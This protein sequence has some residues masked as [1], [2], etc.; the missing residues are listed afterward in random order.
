VSKYITDL[1]IQVDYKIQKIIHYFSRLIYSDAVILIPPTQYAVGTCAE[2]IRHG[3]ELA[4]KTNQNLVLIK[5]WSF[6]QILGFKHGN[7]KLFD[8]KIK[9]FKND[10]LVKL[11][12]LLIKIINNIYFAFRRML[13]MSI[14]KRLGIFSAQQKNKMSFPYYSYEYVVAKLVKLKGTRIAS[15]TLDVAGSNYKRSENFLKTLNKNFSYKNK[16]ICIHVRSSVYYNDGN[17]RNFRNADASNYCALINKAIADGYMVIVLGKVDTEDK[18]SNI[19]SVIDLRKIKH[20]D[21]VDICAIKHCNIYVGMQSGPLD[22]ALLLKKN[23]LI[24]NGYNYTHLSEYRSKMILYLKNVQNERATEY[25][26]NLPIKI[27]NINT[28]NYKRQWIEMSESEL[29]RA[30]IF[31]KNCFEN[32]DIF[33]VELQKSIAMAA[34][35]DI[36]KSN[37]LEAMKQS[38]DS[39]YKL[40]NGYSYRAI[41]CNYE[42]NQAMNQNTCIYK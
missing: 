10:S 12:I 1:V 13:F 38:K 6:N 23:I 27:H 2:E 33:E 34:K 19:E 17:R 18:I 29:E 21:M 35:V 4:Q 16:Y 39:A 20:D 36:V 3:Y 37:L 32:D 8:L 22:L 40:S 31:A 26:L 25:L 9:E 7:S 15:F 42:A 24:V 41:I 30:F 14:I 5:L 11:K 28:L